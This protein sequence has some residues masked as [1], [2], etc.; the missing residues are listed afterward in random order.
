MIDS[1]FLRSSAMSVDNHHFGSSLLYLVLKRKIVFPRRSL[2][3][4]GGGGE[5]SNVLFVTEILF[6]DHLNN[7]IHFIP[8]LLLVYV[9][10]FHLFRKANKG[11]NNKSSF[12]RV[13][14][15]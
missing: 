13:P 2:G 1:F 3:W 11:N 5:G 15:E 8:G 4:L 9:S 14:R 12:M 10:L 6:R 7:H